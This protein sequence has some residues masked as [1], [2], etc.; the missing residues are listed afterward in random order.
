MLLNNLFLLNLSLTLFLIDLEVFSEARDLLLTLLLGFKVL[1]AWLSDLGVKVWVRDFS[2]CDPIGN[3]ALLLDERFFILL[4]DSWSLRVLIM[5]QQT[6][7]VI[8]NLLFLMRDR[9]IW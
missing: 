3:I 8:I 6:V 9:H 7:E 4:V 2:E 5:V 1:L